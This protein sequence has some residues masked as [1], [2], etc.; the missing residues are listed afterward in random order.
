[1]MFLKIVQISTTE[2]LTHSVF[3]I[4]PQAST[5]ATY[6]FVIKISQ[7]APSPFPTIQS[8]LTRLYKTVH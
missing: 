6:L 7:L 4:P 1:M 3:R 8:P 5:F 2:Y